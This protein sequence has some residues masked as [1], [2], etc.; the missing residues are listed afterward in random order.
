MVYENTVRRNDIQPLHE[1]YP[2][3]AQHLVSTA[4]ELVRHGSDFTVVAIAC[5]ILQKRREIGRRL[6]RKSKQGKD[7]DFFR[8][9]QHLKDSG[10]VKFIREMIRV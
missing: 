2:L 9:A 6:Q 7:A 10:T 5:Q 3:N 8:D 4:L 1:P